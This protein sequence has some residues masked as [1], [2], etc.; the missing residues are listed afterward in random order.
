MHEDFDE[1]LGVVHNTIN[2]SA[3]ANRRIAAESLERFLV[4]RRTYHQRDDY[5]A[6]E[7]PPARLPSLYTV[8]DAEYNGELVSTNPGRD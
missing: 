2:D 6:S 4:R 7:A 5:H 3:S 8:I 1:L